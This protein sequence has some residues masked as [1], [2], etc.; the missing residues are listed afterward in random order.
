M[1]AS[2]LNLKFISTSQMW[3][4][5]R[6]AV[7]SLVLSNCRTEKR[8]YTAWA[9]SGHSIHHKI[10]CDSEIQLG[11]RVLINLPEEIQELL[12]PVPQGNPAHYSPVMMSNA[13]YKLAVP[14]RL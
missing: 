2:K 8:F 5:R 9:E 14:W 3:I 11:R 13:D 10:R 1:R 6:S 4:L 7:S 12:G